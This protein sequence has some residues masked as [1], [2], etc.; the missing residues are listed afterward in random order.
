MTTPG[1]WQRARLQAQT[2]PLRL[3]LVVLLGLLLTM[4][5]IATGAAATLF[6]QRYMLQRLDAELAAAKG[7]LVSRALAT[8]AS[9]DDTL[10]P[11]PSLVPINTY[12]VR[13]M[14]PGSPATSRDFNTQPSRE[15]DWPAATD[16]TTPISVGSLAGSDEKWHVVTG[17]TKDSSGQTVNYAVAVSLNTVESTVHRLEFLI[18]LAGLI[19]VPTVSLVG[20]YAVK[21]SFRPLAAIE[22][23]AAAIAAGDLTRRVPVQAS[24]DEVG[25]LSKSLN[26]MLGRIEDSFA[27]R[28]ASEEK[29]RQ[30]VADAS[31][32]LRTP[33]ATVRGYAELF[34][35]GAVREPEDVA[36]AMRRVEDEATRMAVLVDDLLLLTRLD[37]Q[38]GTA[39]TER[40]FLPVDLT[41]VAADSAQDAQALAPGRSI[42][43]TGLRGPI[44]PTEVLGDESRLRQVAT[45]L[46]ANA[47]RYT[48]EGSPIEVL[49][50]SADGTA[51]L[52]V[53]DHGPG[54]PEALR[55]KVFERFYRTDASRNSSHG[56]SGLGLAIVSAIAQAHDG[57]VHV[58]RTD[59]GGATFVLS[60]PLLRED[61]SAALQDDTAAAQACDESSDSGDEASEQTDPDN[62]ILGELTG[63]AQSGDKSAT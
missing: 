1:W 18:A 13:L 28:E 8:P 34:R 10:V 40:P 7:Q 52:L 49:V 47:I 23:T 22:D 37:R 20:W 44:A 29:M 53:R 61:T 51:R 15:P 5:I 58:E 16:I 48:P 2:A 50:G 4:A 26:V 27:V 31:H 41:V 12:V 21:R 42:R 46:M 45:N 55:D 43:L 36:S 35:Q 30:F 9:G 25:S 33:L 11:S 39:T 24:R 19:A 17:T 38:E 54:V 60:L 3:R 14:W 62:V 56:G 59:G 6:L 57:S 32:E 63:S